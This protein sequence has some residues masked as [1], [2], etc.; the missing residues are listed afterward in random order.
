MD[1]LVPSGFIVILTIAL[2]MFI[3]GDYFGDSYVMQQAYNRGYAE[4]CVGTKDLY[5]KG[6]CPNE[7]N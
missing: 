7:K 2:A 1:R 6:E 3:W 4:Y 5:W